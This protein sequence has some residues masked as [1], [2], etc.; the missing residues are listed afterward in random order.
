VKDVIVEYVSF[1]F[2]WTLLSLV[3]RILYGSLSCFWIAVVINTGRKVAAGPWYCS[4]CTRNTMS[5]CMYA[6]MLST[7]ILTF[8]MEHHFLHVLF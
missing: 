4:L 8:K 7:S 3:L 6:T 1:S 5:D 2:L